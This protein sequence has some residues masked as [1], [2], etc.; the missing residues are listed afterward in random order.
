MWQAVE[1][2]HCPPQMDNNNNTNNNNNNKIIVFILLPPNTAITTTIYTNKL[3]RR[4]A[5]IQLN[6]KN[7]C[8]H[9]TLWNAELSESYLV[10]HRE[11]WQAPQHHYCGTWMGPRSSHYRTTPS[12]HRAN[13]WTSAS[14]NKIPTLTE[15]KQNN[16]TALGHVT[17]STRPLFA[18]RWLRLLCS[19]DWTHCPIS[20]YNFRVRP[21]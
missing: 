16:H 14:P 5:V 12:P 13:V 18:S 1:C 19:E 8:H 4:V 7:S 9:T 6:A 20:A 17:Q 3:P 15:N 2:V 11:P 10:S 21:H